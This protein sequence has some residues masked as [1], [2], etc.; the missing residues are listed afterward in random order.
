M[1][2][3]FRSSRLLLAIQFILFVYE[4]C[5]CLFTCGS[6][7]KLIGSSAD[8]ASTINSVIDIDR[9]GFIDHFIWF[10][11][12]FFVLFSFFHSISIVNWVLVSIWFS[13]TCRNATPANTLYLHIWLDAIRFLIVVCFAFAGRALFSPLV[14]YN[15]WLP[16]G[17]ADPLKNDPTFDYSPPVLDRVRYW[18]D[19]TNKE[20]KDV[21]VLGVPSKRQFNKQPSQ[22]PTQAVEAQP[23]V[24]NRRNFMMPEVC[25]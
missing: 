6:N 9:L 7:N 11:I 19:N 12:F 16:V 18:N 25:I 5:V 21:L 20:K 13:S 1:I 23:F 10:D 8:D 17:R 22:Q 3:D 24:S 2:C 4:R 15:E 14:D